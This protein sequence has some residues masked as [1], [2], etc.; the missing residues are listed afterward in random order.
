MGGQHLLEPLDHRRGAPGGRQRDDHRAARPLRRGRATV[1]SIAISFGV[2]LALVEPARDERRPRPRRGGP[3]PAGRSPGRTSPRSRPR[4]PRPWRSPTASPSLVILRWTPV[5]GPPTVTIDP[6]CA[7]SSA[8]TLAM[9][10][11]RRRRR[12]RARRRA[13][14]GRRRRA[15]ASRAR[16]ASSTVLSHSPAGIDE[17]ERRSGAASSL[18]AAAEQVELAD[19]LGALGVQTRRRSPRRAR[20]AARAGCGRGS[21]TRRP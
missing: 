8:S 11:S 12:G 17:L 7:V 15:R 10:S 2:V 13:A 4:G 6:S 14:G 16:S 5:T 18:T 19:R 21:R 3:R 20:R 9:P 1:I